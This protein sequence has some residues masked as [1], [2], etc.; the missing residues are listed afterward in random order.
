MICGAFCTWVDVYNNLI[1]KPRF[2]VHVAFS[3]IEVMYHDIPPQLQGHGQ[4]GRG[5]G[6]DFLAAMNMGV[7]AADLM[8]DGGRTAW[9]FQFHNV[10]SWKEFEYVACGLS[11]GS[12]QD[13][14]SHMAVQIG[15]TAMTGDVCDPAMWVH[16][17]TVFTLLCLCVA[18]LL[19]MVAIVQFATG[20]VIRRSKSYIWPA[21]AFAM[22]V[23]VQILATVIGFIIVGMFDAE[24]VFFVSGGFLLA[25]VAMLGTG[26]SVCVSFMTIE[27]DLDYEDY[28]DEK[29]EREY[30]M[31][32]QEQAYGYAAQPPP[33]YA[34]P[35]PYAAYSPPYA[36]QGYPQYQ[37]Q[38]GYSQYQQPGYPQQGYPRYP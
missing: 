6:S 35:Q 27:D 7:Y 15:R 31:R 16:R 34:Q 33:S 9:M 14:M 11:M 36:Q 4:H 3:S 17:L 38:Q 18:G 21:C 24:R 30:L 20:A 23:V 32:R 19:T 5:G 2:H 13:P 10:R 28:L 22:L 8:D 26:F 37:Q 12:V 1:G 25:F 29:E